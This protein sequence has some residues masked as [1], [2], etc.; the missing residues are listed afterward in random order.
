M[1][2]VF[3]IQKL[4][5]LC[6]AFGLSGMVAH[7]QK[8]QELLPTMVWHGTIPITKEADGVLLQAEG[9]EVPKLETAEQFTPPFKITAK[10]VT[11]TTETRI[12]YG[13]G[14][15]IFNWA[16]KPDQIRVHDL[17]TAAPNPIPGKGLK[18]GKEHTIVIEVEPR[19]MVLKVSG[20]QIYSSNGDYRGLKNTIAIGPAMGSKIHVHAFD[21]EQPAPKPN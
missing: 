12:H 14:L 17:L 1:K 7:A 11:D 16:N 10:V 21:I 4:F 18:A 3:L 9:S 5:V 13:K 15:F 6:A 20:Q 2:Y 8:K 19:R